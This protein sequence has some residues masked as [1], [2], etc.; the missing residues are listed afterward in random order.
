MYFTKEFR[1]SVCNKI[2]GNNYEAYVVKLRT[3][4]YSDDA[5]EMARIVDAM[6][7]AWHKII[8]ERNKNYLKNYRGLMKRLVFE[9]KEETGCFSPIFYLFCIRK[10]TDLPAQEEYRNRIA[11]E[12]IKVQTYIKWF[13]TW[14]SA[15]KMCS[16]VSVG[17]SLVELE[18]LERVLGEFCTNEKYTLFPLIDEAKRAL[19]KKA[20]G[21]GKHKLVTFGGIFKEMN[22][23]M[24][25][26]R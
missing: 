21:D 1:K 20:S 9:Y 19:L 17:F 13:S 12:K 4:I 16:P 15:V 14:A 18:N 22:R 26:E 23:Q 10:F 7:V 2:L 24:S 25:V 5:E 3:G 11:I 8:R 6:F